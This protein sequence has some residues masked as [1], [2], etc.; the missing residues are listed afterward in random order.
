MKIVMKG[1]AWLLII[2]GSVGIAANA[3]ALYLSM[4]TDLQAS[5]AT[6]AADLPSDDSEIFVVIVFHL[7]L[8]IAGLAI[9]NKSNT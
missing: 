5:A 4:T 7:L 3:S 8:L 9:K 6:S 2:W 1:L